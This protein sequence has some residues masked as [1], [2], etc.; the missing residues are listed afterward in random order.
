MKHPLFIALL[1]LALCASRSPILAQTAPR[2]LPFQARLADAAGRSFPDG[3]RAIRFQIFAEMLGGSPL[4][5]GEVH[6]TTINGGLVNVQLGTKAP[7][8]HVDFN[9]ELYLEIT[10][11][12]N[13]DEKL[14]A[15]GSDGVDPRH[16]R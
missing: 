3:P 7:L 9:Q 8:T 11:D 13:N 16:D 12:S 1:A 14:D 5:A 4:W 10:I 15:I 2:L 6:R